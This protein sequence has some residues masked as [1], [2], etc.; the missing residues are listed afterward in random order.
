MTN[1]PEGAI[2]PGATGI[3]HGPFG[4]H[5]VPT[6]PISQFAAGIHA[7]KAAAIR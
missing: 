5:V 3:K 6:F 2:R 7:R 1:T 4:T